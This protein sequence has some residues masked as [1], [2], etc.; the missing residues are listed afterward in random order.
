MKN[1]KERNFLPG[2]K[3]AAPIAGAAF[4]KNSSPYL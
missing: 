3:K 2:T 4:R 1:L